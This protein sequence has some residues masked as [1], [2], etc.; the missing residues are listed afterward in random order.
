MQ[1]NRKTIAFVLVALMALLVAWEPWRP[2]P[3]ANNAPADVGTK[4]FPDFTDPL[5][6]KSL[7]IVTYDEDN[8]TISDFNVAQ[9]NGVWSIPSHSNYPADAREHMAQAATALLDLE[10]LGVASTTPGDQELYGVLP[11]DPSKLKPG[12]VGIGRRVTLKDDKDKVLADLIIGKEIKDQP[13][14]HYVRRADRDQIYRV[15]VKTD[16]FSTKFE[17]WIEKNLLKL[18]AFDVR[19]VDLNDYSLTEH[20]TREGVTLAM[21]KN[22]LVKLA[23]DDAKSAWSLVAMSTFDKEGDPVSAELAADEELNAEKL[24][25]L[26]SALNDLLIVDVQRKPKGLSQDLRASEEFD[27]DNEAKVSLIERGFYPVPPQFDIYSREG[28]VTCATK[29]GVRYVLRFGNLAGGSTAK[30]EKKPGEKE[31]SNPALNRYLFVMAQLD[32]SQ[33]PKPQLEAVPGEVKPA[34]AQPGDEKADA[35]AGEDKP[36]E[37]KSESKEASPAGEKAAAEKAPEEKTAAADDAP[38]DQPAP[39]AKKSAAKTKKSSAQAKQTAPQ[40]AAAPPAAAPPA[41]APAV[42]TAKAAEPAAK[43]DAAKPDAPQADAP[44]DEKKEEKPAAVT[45]EQRIAMQKEN[46]RKQDEYDTSIKK[47]QDRVKEL[48]DRFADWYF[49]ISDDVYKKIHLGRSDIVKKKDAA[50]NTDKAPGKTETL[51]GLGDLKDLEKGLKAK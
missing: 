50:E 25:T 42:D 14:L 2:A 39:K 19:G 32:E 1:E 44:A 49:I 7:S 48:N 12:A 35:K 9:V 30:D 28:E 47:A 40:N 13:S 41:D 36:A 21:K 29:D 18:N 33:I 24:N 16:K 6:A 3:A 45:E 34:D 8:A 46:K 51:P 20:V 23:Y 43:P 38:Q 10:I 31:K 15:N 27:K 17:D 5:A 4:L 37:E 22:S 11:L 26:K